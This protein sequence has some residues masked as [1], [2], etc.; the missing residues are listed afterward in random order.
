MQQGARLGCV[1]VSMARI[2]R[3]QWKAPI[4]EESSRE[5]QDLGKLHGTIR[6][7]R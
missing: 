3:H 5:G 7:L 4:V 6:G 1:N 2:R